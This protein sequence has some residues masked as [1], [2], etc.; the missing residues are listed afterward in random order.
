MMTDNNTVV[1][2]V[3]EDKMTDYNTVDYHVGEDKDD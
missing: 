1:C 3:G 2:R